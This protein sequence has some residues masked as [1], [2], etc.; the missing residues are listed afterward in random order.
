MPAGGIGLDR[1]PRLRTAGVGVGALGGILERGQR[2]CESGDAENPR[3][4]A[5]STSEKVA[6][7][8]LYVRLKA[9]AE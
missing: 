7:S 1:R 9:S 2:A 4:E 6:F 5:C 8:D 3:S